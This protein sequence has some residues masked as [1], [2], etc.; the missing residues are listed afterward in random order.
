MRNRIFG[1]KSI[2][3]IEICDWNDDYVNPFGVCKLWI[4]GHCLHDEGVKIFYPTVLAS[5]T[6]IAKRA[7]H[8]DE[9]PHSLNSS[10]ALVEYVF[11]ENSEG[12]GV[13]DHLFLMASGFDDFVKVFFKGS[14]F[15]KFL[16]CRYSDDLGSDVVDPIY[17]VDVPNSVINIVAEE[18]HNF[19]RGAENGHN[20]DTHN[21]KR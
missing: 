11:G 12:D 1:E 7:P 10:L 16:F 5:V 13:G 2:F 14:E 3:S 19:V 6:G 17:I 20:Q 8:L 21:F 15:T 4:G 18:F 9:V